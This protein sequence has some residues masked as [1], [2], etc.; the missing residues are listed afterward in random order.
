MNQFLWIDLPPP[1]ES[2]RAPVDEQR[3][4]FNALKMLF[5]KSRSVPIFRRLI[6]E[7]VSL[8]QIEDAINTFQN[9]EHQIILRAGFTSL[10]SNSPADYMYLL[11]STVGNDSNRINGLERLLS[12]VQKFASVD[13]E[14]EILSSSYVAFR[15][16]ENYETTQSAALKFLDCQ[17]GVSYASIGQF[18]AG[19]GLQFDDLTTTSFNN[20]FYGRFL[21]G[22]KIAE[23]LLTKGMFV[24]QVFT[25]KRSPS[26]KIIEMTPTSPRVYVFDPANDRDA[27]SIFF[28]GNGDIAI[29]SNSKSSLGEYLR[30]KA[31]TELVDNLSE[32]N[33]KGRTLRQ[34]LDAV[35]EQ[36]DLGLMP[37]QGNYLPQIENIF[38]SFLG[39][40]LS[41]IVQPF[42]HPFYKT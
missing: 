14:A 3:E 36:N 42:T 24:P 10:N 7:D 8:N 23:L 17:T 27:P 35:Y 6:S 22:E 34:E 16:P 37:G 26:Y 19:L 15:V 21:D 4:Y 18:A 9:G 31:F 39:L 33:G 13:K 11:A 20:Q 30:M 5:S 12:K 2:P 41:Q 1:M 29:S 38:R 25:Q 40:S 28:G 32:N